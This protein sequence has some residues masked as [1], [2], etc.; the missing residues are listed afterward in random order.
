MLSRTNNI[1]S[2]NEENSPIND[3]N[4]I[5]SE[6]DQ[7]KWKKI[8]ENNN[9]SSLVYSGYLKSNIKRK[10]VLKK[11]SNIFKDE[12]NENFQFCINVLKE[13]SFLITFCNFELCTKLLEIITYENKNNNSIDL[14]LIFEYGGVDLR[15]FIKNNV[16]Y[17]EM[18]DMNVNVIK[19]I[20]FQIILI[21]CHLHSLQI[22]HSDLTAKNILINEEGAIKICDFGFSLAKKFFNPKETQGIGGTL[23]YMAPESLFMALMRYDEKKIGGKKIDEKIDI[24]GVGVIMV[25]LYTKKS[26]FFEEKKQEEKHFINDY[27]KQLNYIFNQLKIRQNFS[28]NDEEEKFWKSDGALK[29]IYLKDRDNLDFS[30]FFID[31]VGSRLLRGDPDAM[32]L[33]QKLLN[34][35]PDKRISAEEA[36]KSK[37][38]ETCK[39]YWPDLKKKISYFNQKELDLSF[40]EKVSQINGKENKLK[41][42]KDEFN[43]IKNDF[44]KMKN[45]K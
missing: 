45:A 6:K 44:Y 28:D 17:R 12:G 11:I 40:K 33:L 19:W 4:F 9:T 13:I 8:Y 39:E 23:H 2:D 27:L 1:I 21:L 29:E 36:L 5:W 35:N 37:Y 42:L 14:Y 41:F 10:I 32:D 18:Y 20:L 16:D 26:P 3:I 25:E 43:K 30:K 22:I 7:Y 38:F 15:K 31:N 24:W 34:I